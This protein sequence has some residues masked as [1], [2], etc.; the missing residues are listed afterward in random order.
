ML[1]NQPPSKC[2]QRTS[3]DHDFG[4]VKST[5]NPRIISPMT[6]TLRIIMAPSPVPKAAPAR[7]YSFTDV[8]TT[9][10]AA[11]IP[12]TSHTII[13][14]L[15]R[16]KVHLMILPKR[17]RL[18]LRSCLPHRGHLRASLLTSVLHSGQFTRAITIFLCV[19]GYPCMKSRIRY[20]DH[21]YPVKH[22]SP[23]QPNLTC[24]NSGA[25]TIILRE[26]IAQYLITQNDI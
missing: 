25:W 17:D 2:G 6:Q 24:P 19:T 22:T 20:V 21:L 11:F 12:P 10:V 13:T 4:L 7:S 15:N 26:K 23:N 14:M 9:S 1:L 5:N 8:L 3:C 16:M 18:S